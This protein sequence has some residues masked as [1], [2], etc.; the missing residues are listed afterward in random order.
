MI[1]RESIYSYIDIYEK[2]KRNT[3]NMRDELTGL[4][5]KIQKNTDSSL[6]LPLSFS[7]CLEDK[8]PQRWMNKY[9]KNKI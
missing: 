7:E 3:E 8:K 1:R 2:E 9:N 5:I 4:A 6:L